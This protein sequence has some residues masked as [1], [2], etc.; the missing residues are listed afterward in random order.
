[1]G[2][3]SADRLNVISVSCPAPLLENLAFEEELPPGKAVRH[4]ARDHLHGA[5]VDI[6][7]SQAAH[8]D[9]LLY[10]SDVRMCSSFLNRQGSDWLHI[11]QGSGPG[12]LCL[13]CQ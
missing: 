13:L 6:K 12:L 10:F 8:P 2:K 4:G 9:A 7:R 3:D 1:M 5:R 11:L